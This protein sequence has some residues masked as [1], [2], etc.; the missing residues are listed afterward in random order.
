MLLFVAIDPESKGG[1]FSV[2]LQSSNCLLQENK[3]VRV[4]PRPQAKSSP[5]LS[6]SNSSSRP[7]ITRD[8]NGFKDT[9]RFRISW[10]VSDI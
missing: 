7:S 8:R 4:L 2:L 5:S 9:N 6:S 3:K 10:K 1:H